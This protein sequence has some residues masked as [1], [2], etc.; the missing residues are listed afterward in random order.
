MITLRIWVIK[1]DTGTILQGVVFVS[2]LV[3]MI[4]SYGLW[5]RAVEMN[6]SDVCV[7]ESGI[8]WR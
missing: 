3:E 6:G 2:V 1:L 7:G 4:V 8:F 5:I